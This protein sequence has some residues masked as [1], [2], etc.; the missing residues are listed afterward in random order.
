MTATVFHAPASLTDALA[1]LAQPVA[2]TRVLAGGTDL[3]VQMRAGRIS[4]ARVVDIKRIPEMI[5]IRVDADG[6]FLIGAATPCAVIGEHTPLS[7]QWPGVS[8]AAQLI[9]SKQVQ[10][11]ASLGGNLC[12][13]SPAADSVPALVAAGAR[14]MVA[15]AGGQRE[16]P[17]E[18]LPVGP[19]RLALAPGELLCAIRIP[20]RGAHGGDAYLRM[21]PRTEMI[22]EARVALGAVAPTVVLVAQAAQAL[23]GSKLDA[24]ALQAFARAVRA[25]CKPIDDKRGTAAYRT[26]VA[27]VLALRAAS[28][29]YQRAT[30]AP[31]TAGDSRKP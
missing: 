15:S 28:I 14:C 29:A 11:R 5:G 9:G 22:R 4:P 7:R 12:N 3:V 23:V 2:D 19:G 13:A 30:G 1:L 20:A 17:V 16:L 18:D 27:G 25:A 8:E 6:S 26:R 31:A 10:G 24:P 21:I